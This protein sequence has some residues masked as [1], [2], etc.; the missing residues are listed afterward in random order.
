MV[1]IA[2]QDLVRATGAALHVG[3]A[4]RVCRGCAIDSR[5]VGKDAIFVAFPGERVDGNAFAP[6]AIE[7]GAACVVLTVEPSEELLSLAAEHGRAVLTCDD[8]TEFLLR[9]A[10]D[11]PLSA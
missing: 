2:V 8:P 5:E 6:K 7:A 4:E 3:A 10:K 9:L 1:E 11:V